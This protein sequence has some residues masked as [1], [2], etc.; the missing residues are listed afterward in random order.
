FDDDTQV[1]DRFFIGGD[2]FRGFASEGLG[3]RD[4]F[5]GLLPTGLADD[6][7]T[8]EDESVVQTVRDDALG[9]N[10]FAV[11]RA[12]VSFPLGLPEEL[13]IFGGVF[14]DAGSLWKLDNDVAFGADVQSSAFEPRLSAGGL[15]FV[16]TPFGP[17]ELSLGFPLIDESFDESELFRVTVGTRF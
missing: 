4:V 10:L 9:G 5:N 2:S 13:G 15:L 11:V 12:Q 8:P 14:V 1:Q 17:L 7:D 16:D 6:P 3:P